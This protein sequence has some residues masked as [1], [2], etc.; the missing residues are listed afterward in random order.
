MSKQ[1]LNLSTISG[2]QEI[3]DH[4]AEIVSGGRFEVNKGATPDG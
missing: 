4:S 3:S 2:I 1:K